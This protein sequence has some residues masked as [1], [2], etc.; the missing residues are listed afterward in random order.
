MIKVS[1][2]IPVY[3]VE[4]YLPACLDSVLAQTLAEIEVICIDDASPDG[5]GAILDDYAARDERVRVVHL[6][7]NRRQGYGRDRGMDLARGRYI[8]FLD[9]DDLIVPDALERLYALAE[10][11]DLQG[12]FFDSQVIYENEKLAVRYASYPAVRRGAYPTGTQT[13]AALFARFIE[14]EEWTCYVQRQFWSLEFLR[15]HDIRFPDGV[16]HEDELFS[17]E[18]ILLCEKV[19]Y[20]PE[21]FFIRR[22]R[23]NSVLTTRPTAKNFH[24]YFM[25]FCLMEEF[26]RRK[27]I[28]SAAADVNLARIYERAERYYRDLTARGEDVSAW[29][30]PEEL[31]RLYFFE[32]MQKRNAYYERLP[33]GLAAALVPY[34]HVYIYGAGVVA[35]RAYRSLEMHAIPVDGFVVTSHKDNPLVLHSRHVYTPDELPTDRS[36]TVLLLAMTTGYARQAE[37]TLDALGWRHIRFLP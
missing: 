24:G 21:T 19:R 9:S 20:V 29:F 8:Y 6:P 1:V 26:L 12:V 11:N 27:Q 34:A 14:Q 33:Q 5:C 4:P 25:N 22:Y 23:E 10:N 18:A 32:A 7:E 3:M 15:R 37:A 16:E 35:E 30:R 28:A 36:D 13:G 31:E 2:V 17:F